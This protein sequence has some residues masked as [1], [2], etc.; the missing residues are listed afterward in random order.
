MKSSLCRFL[1][2]PVTSSLF[3]PNI[4]LN[5]LFS[6]TLSLSSSLNPFYS[7]FFYPFLPMHLYLFLHKIPHNTGFM[8]MSYFNNNCINTNKISTLTFLFTFFTL[9]P[10]PM[11]CFHYLY[12]LREGYFSKHSPGCSPGFLVHVL[13]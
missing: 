11:N 4:L 10:S 3:G 7:L 8:K 12:F 1:Q 5:I 2:P 6:N 13:Q 9:F